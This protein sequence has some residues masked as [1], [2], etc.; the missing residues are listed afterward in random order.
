M[1]YKPSKIGLFVAHYSGSDLA[2]DQLSDGTFRIAVCAPS[3]GFSVT[4]TTYEDVCETVEECLSEQ[5]NMECRVVWLSDIFKR[6]FVSSV[7]LA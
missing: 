7:T 6:N 2:I 5:D 4:E 3:K 1:T